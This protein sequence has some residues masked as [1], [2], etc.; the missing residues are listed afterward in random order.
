MCA[1]ASRR[2]C[3]PWLRQRLCRQQRSLALA[4]AHHDA[5][6]R[7]A[8]LAAQVDAVVV[9][10]ELALAALAALAQRHR[11]RAAPRELEHRA[12]LCLAGPRDGARAQQVARLK[13]AARDGVVAQLLLGR[14]VEVAVVGLAHRMA[15]D[16]HRE[17]HVPRAPRVALVQVRQRWWALR[18]SRAR[19]G[20]QRLERDHPLPQRGGEVLAAERAQ[21][22]V[23][24]LLDVARRPIIHERQPEDV[25]AGVLGRHRRAQLGAR[26]HHRRHLQLEVKHLALRIDGG[27]GALGQHLAARPPHCGP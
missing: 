3:K 16:G 24:E 19:E 4:K 17:R 1:R 12:I 21:R 11:A 8:R 5:P 22:H 7:A 20:L 10:D 25:L 9:L 14:P 27:L 2:R 13:A 23:L 26:A 15:I 6:I 18:L